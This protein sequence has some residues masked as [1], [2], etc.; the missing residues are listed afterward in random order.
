MSEVQTLYVELSKLEQELKEQPHLNSESIQRKLEE[1]KHRSNALQE[2][3]AN[4]NAIVEKPIVFN[5]GRMML[6]D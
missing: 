6:K 4:Q 2:Q 3:T 5:D 1:L